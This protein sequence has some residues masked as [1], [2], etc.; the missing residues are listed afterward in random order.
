MVE[1]SGRWSEVCM[2]ESEDNELFLWVMNDN[3]S[4]NVSFHNEIRR[5]IHNEIVA[6]NVKLDVAADD[7]Q[8]ELMH[9]KHVLINNHDISLTLNSFLMQWS[10]LE[11]ILHHCATT[12]YKNVTIKYANSS[13]QKYNPVIE[14]IKDTSNYTPWLVIISAAK[15]RN[16]LLHINGRISLSRDSKWIRTVINKTPEHFKEKHDRLI[17]TND[18]INYFMDAVRTVLH[19]LVPT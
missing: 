6:L 16:C 14:S 19:D 7:K 4:W 13:I 3:L 5:L 2:A 17:I 9:E 18:Y 12:Y 11:E 15:I 1:K 10:L 8:R